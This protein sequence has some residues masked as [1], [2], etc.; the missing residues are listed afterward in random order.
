M[1]LPVKIC[2]HAFDCANFS[3]LGLMLDMQLLVKQWHKYLYMLYSEHVTDWGLLACHCILQPGSHVTLLMNMAAKMWDV[4]V[5]W[6]FRST[7]KAD[8]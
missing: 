7:V 2:Q 6:Q 3:C 1:G 8:R 5:A 4:A